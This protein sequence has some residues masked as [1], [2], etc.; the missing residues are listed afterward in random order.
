VPCA[1]FSERDRR[2]DAG[3]DTEL[4]DDPADVRT[5]GPFPDAEPLRD[6]TV[7]LV[8]RDD[9][10]HF[11]FTFAEH[12]GSVVPEVLLADHCWWGRGGLDG[13]PAVH[14]RPAL[15]SQDQLA[16]AHAP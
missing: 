13:E 11:P 5:H 6:L 4:E 14:G 10:Q 9:H 15:L 1:P 2:A 16:S 3:G 8:E 7:G 12:V